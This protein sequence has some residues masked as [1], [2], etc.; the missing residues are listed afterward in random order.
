MNDLMLRIG[1]LGDT[2]I[3]SLNELLCP[4]V[5]TQ[6][7]PNDIGDALSLD[8]TQAWRIH[9]VITTDDPFLALHESPAPKGLGAIIDA[10]ERAGGDSEALIAARQ[11]VASFAAIIHEFPDGRAGLDAALASRVPKALHAAVKQARKDVSAGMAKLLGLRSAVRYV[12]GILAPSADNDQTA[13]VIAV[14][15][16]KDLRRLRVGPSPVLF[17]GRTYT[18]MPSSKEPALLTID[19]NTDPDPRLR[20]LE[21]YCSIDPEALTLESSG[22]ELRLTLSDDLPSINDTVTVFFGQRI[23]RSMA[24]YESEDR[25]HELVHHAPVLPSDVNVFDT[26]IHKDLYPDANPPKV[27]IERFGFNPVAQASKPD[28]RAYRLDDIEALTSLGTGLD[29]VAIRAVPKL[30]SLLADV[31][32]KSGYRPTDFRLFRTSVEYLPPGFAVVVWLP[33]SGNNDQK[34]SVDQSSINAR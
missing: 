20:M 25:K 34:G 17:S 2:L 9:R 27:T 3:R 33:L 22:A 21:D 10:A 13:D 24:R 6:S 14:A 15:G 7:K 5:G 19:G 18:Q 11:V 26:F 4:I 31:F 29:F 28:D 30:P 1:D 23:A 8:R 32:D 16:Y 12:G